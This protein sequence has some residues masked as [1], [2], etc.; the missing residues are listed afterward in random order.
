MACVSE[1]ILE[2]ITDE[3][4]SVDRAWRYTYLNE[5][6]LGRVQRLKGEALTREAVLGKNDASARCRPLV[7]NGRWH[8]QRR[9]RQRFL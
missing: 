5:R 3:F 4:F 1:N 8:S 6:A 2:S 7:G 9:V